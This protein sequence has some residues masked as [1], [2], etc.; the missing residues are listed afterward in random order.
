MSMII[1]WVVC[2]QTEV[3]NRICI[4]W[5]VE[6]ILAVLAGGWL[7]VRVTDYT[8]ECNG[9]SLDS[10]MCP[11]TAN[12]SINARDTKVAYVPPPGENPGGGTI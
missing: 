3:A 4:V 11:P 5:Y 2:L 6:R 7:V 1:G 12:R 8:F 10:S 9:M